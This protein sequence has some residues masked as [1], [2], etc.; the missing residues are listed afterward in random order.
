LIFAR[1][2]GIIIGKALFERI[3]LNCFLT[4]SIWR[5]ICNKPVRQGDFFFYDKE[6][7]KN[8]KFI[9]E[10]PIGTD[11]GLNFSYL[12]SSDIK[13]A[14]NVP[15]KPNGENI[16]VNDTNKQEFINLL[17]NY[18][19]TKTC[20]HYIDVVKEGINQVMPVAFLEVF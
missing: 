10:N 1:L 3:S 4:K 5:Q 16:P 18:F 20:K 2:L 9:K 11:L 14:T 19:C 17:I 7:Y 12:I 13:E 15:L 6:I 8:L